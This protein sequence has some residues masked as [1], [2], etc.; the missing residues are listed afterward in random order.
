M[1]NTHDLIIIGA[2]PGGHAAAEQ[3]ARQGAKVAIIEKNKWGGTCTHRGCVPTKALLACS[4]QYMNVKKLK[5]LGISTGEVSVD[6]T[7][8][9][10]HQQQMVTISSLG[11]QKS[12]KDAGVDLMSGEGKI[13]NPGEVL[14]TP[15][16]GDAQRLVADNIIIAWGSKPLLPPGI[17]PSQRILTSDSFLA[18]NTLPESVVIVGGSVIGVEFATFLAELGVKVTVVELLDQII[19]CE[20]EEVAAFL[21]QEL[22]RLGITVHTSA[23]M[24]ALHEV[25]DGVQLKAIQNTQILE[26]KAEYAMICTGRKPVL[27]FDELNQCGIEYDKKGII[28]NENQRTSREGIYAVGDVTG[29]VML[30][31]RAIQQGRAVA[32]YLR[33][34]R[35]IKYREEAI[36]SVIYTHPSVARVGLTERQA[37]EEGLNVETK[38]VEYATNIMARTELK[39]NGFVKAVF[40]ED[41]LIGVTIIGDDAGELIAPMSLAVANEMGRK[42]LKKWVIP[43]PTLSEILHLL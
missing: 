13:I 24:E 36:P 18:L 8:V 26:L 14:L 20:D 42:E 27:L 4:K 43:H 34:D 21:R 2:G 28:I 19:P 35:S 12:L 23:R 33:G 25:P 11:V 3:A 40:C 30:A 7:A 6:Y 37:S 1:S 22:T 16:Q 38:R 29:G 15:P 41:K 32:D 39:G 10:R 5:R 9:K 31:H 17:N